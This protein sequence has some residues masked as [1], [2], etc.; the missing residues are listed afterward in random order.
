MNRDLRWRFMSLQVLMLIVFTICA[1]FLFWAANYTH[2]SVRT[3][4]AAQSIAFPPSGSPAISAAALTPCASLAKGAVCPIATGP[5]VGA[6]NSAAMTKYAGQTMTTGDQAQTYANS[7]IQV[8][9]SDMGYTYSGISGLA[10]LHPTNATY[11]TLDATIFK[12]TTLRSMLLNA[13]GWWTIGTYAGYAAIAVT[14]A[15]VVVLLA[16]VFE[17]VGAFRREPAPRRARSTIKKP[18]VVPAA[19]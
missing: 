18:A 6:A 13:Y 16:F 17:L 5:S 9:L 2:S 4:L 10:L 11:Q 15:A 3:Q 8:H 1:V 14:L 19:V 7:F 12:G